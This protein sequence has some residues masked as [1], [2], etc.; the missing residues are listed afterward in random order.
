MKPNEI[1]NLAPDEISEEVEKRREELLDLRFQAA[2]GQASNP[3]R[4]RTAKREIAQ[5]LT[6]AK[7]KEGQ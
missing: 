3:R 4:I 1:R 6:I 7:E 5:L 2:V